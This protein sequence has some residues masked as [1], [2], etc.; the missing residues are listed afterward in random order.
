MGSAADAARTP[1]DGRSAALGGAATVR[2]SEE[3]GLPAEDEGQKGGGLGP[4]GPPTASVSSP[5]RRPNAQEGREAATIRV[6]RVGR[7]RLA[8]SPSDR[9]L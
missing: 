8:A 6:T 4:G 5:G 2:E 1:S 9:A 7:N 3:G